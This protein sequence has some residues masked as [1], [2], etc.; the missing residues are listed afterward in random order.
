MRTLRDLPLDRGRIGSAPACEA[1]L[2]LEAAS[3]ISPNAPP[4]DGEDTEVGAAVWEAV[5]LL[6]VATT[7]CAGARERERERE[8]VLERRKFGDMSLEYECGCAE[9]AGTGSWSLSPSAISTLQ[10]S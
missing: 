1:E 6:D 7:T 10:G 3:C 4:Y 5:V 8:R 2:L 9:L